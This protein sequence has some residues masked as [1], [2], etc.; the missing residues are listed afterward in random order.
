MSATTRRLLFPAWHWAKRDNVNAAVRELR[1]NQWMPREE[2]LALQRTKLERLLSFAARDVPYYERVLHECGIR[3]G[4]PLSGQDFLRVPPL[5]KSIIRSNKDALISRNL[6]GNGLRKNSTSGST[7][8]AIHFYTDFR[9]LP[10]RR[11]SMI[12]GDS[13]TGWRLGDRIVRIWGAPVHA[14]REAGFKGKLHRLMSGNRFL[15]SFDLSPAKMDEYLETIREFKAALIVAYSGPLEELAAHCARGTK[16]PHLKA[17]ISSAETLWP[18]Q[19]QI[20]ESAFGVEVFNRYGSRELGHVAG[21]C[22]EHD[23]LHI[24]VDRFLVEVV[25]N[26]GRPCAP[27]EVGR[28]LVTDLDNYGMPLIRYDIGDRGAM[29]TK[30]SCACGRFLPMLRNIEGRTLDIVRT[31]GG[32][33]IGGTFWTLLLRSRPGFR[34]FQVVQERLDGVTVRFIADPDFDRGILEYFTARIKDHCGSDFNV[35]FVRTESIDLT[36]SGK[37]RLIVSRLKSDRQAAATPHA[38]SSVRT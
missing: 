36:G 11:A 33:G 34:Q 6:A 20:I 15:S 37:R 16:F 27:G 13:W 32:R 29:S 7:G 9:S 22:E 25:D 35:D 8:E 1:E 14:R 18:H 19:R 5:T 26:E 24:S 17:I 23:G 30:E 10:Y 38:E 21:E 3:E 12:R 2:L 4:Q 28:I 31:P